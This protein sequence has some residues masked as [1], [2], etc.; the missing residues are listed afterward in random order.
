MHGTALRRVGGRA[1]SSLPLCSLRPVP[2]ER[3]SC[4]PHPAPTCSSVLRPHGPTDSRREERGQG[5]DPPEK[6]GWPRSSTS[7]A[8]GGASTTDVRRCL[9]LVHLQGSVQQQHPAAARSMSFPQIE[10]ISS[11]PPLSG[12]K[13]RERKKRRAFPLLPAGAGGVTQRAHG[14]GG[15]YARVKTKPEECDHPPSL[16][17]SCCSTN[18]ARNNV[19]SGHQSK[20]TNGQKECG[21]PWQ[22][23]GPTL[24]CRR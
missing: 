15:A 14:A 17:S 21:F 12:F 9:A 22:G 10:K 6:C 2:R 7:R 18:N 4:T 16:L 24:C 5:R 23:Y 8:R 20:Q 11:F 13:R 19:I 3:H 1:H